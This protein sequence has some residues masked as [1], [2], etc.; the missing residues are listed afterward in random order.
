VIYDPKR[1]LIITQGTVYGDRAP[2]SPWGNEGITDVFQSVAKTLDVSTVT[3]NYAPGLLVGT[4]TK[5]PP[6]DFIT[7]EL[8][9]AGGAPFE[10]MG[11]WNKGLYLFTRSY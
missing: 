9:G 10:P 8:S 1:A 7:W 3:E 6:I 4:I 2:A 5:N 11:F